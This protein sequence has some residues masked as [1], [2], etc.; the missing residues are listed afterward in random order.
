[1]I[2][3][4]IPSFGSVY[5]T[6]DIEWH[7]NQGDDEIWGPSYNYGSATK[8]HGGS[9]DDKLYTGFQDYA[10]NYVYGGSGKDEIRTDFWQQRLT[11]TP[12]VAN[13][14]WIFGDYK[15]GEDAL[16]KDLWGDADVIHAGIDTTNDYDIEVWAGDGDDIIHGGEGWYGSEL[17]GNNGND[18]IHLP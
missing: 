12:A 5:N 13:D 2:P 17:R 18:T 8:L 11:G 3:T 1:M 14:I 15:Y 16:D 7:G 10:F 9:G 6:A 4:K